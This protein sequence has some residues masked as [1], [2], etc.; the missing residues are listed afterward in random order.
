VQIDGITI[1][2]NP[3]VLETRLS[4][5]MPQAIAAFTSEYSAEMDDR[6]ER[7]SQMY[8]LAERL[9]NRAATALEQTNDLA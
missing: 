4:R 9:A 2:F 6:P 7:R 3:A 8:A 1:R 5:K